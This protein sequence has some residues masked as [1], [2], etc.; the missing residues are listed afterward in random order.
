MA[1]CV[2]QYQCSQF[3]CLATSKLWI[4]ALV[5]DEIMLLWGSQCQSYAMLWFNGWK[6]VGIVTFTV[7]RSRRRDFCGLPLPKYCCLLL[8]NFKACNCR[9]KRSRTGLVGSIKVENV[10]L[11][12]RSYDFGG[13]S[14]SKLWLLGLASVDV[15][16]L[17][18]GQCRSSNIRCQSMSKLWQFG[19]VDVE[20][21]KCWIN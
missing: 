8:F 10:A 6:K 3:C 2:I 4:L 18:A 17:W 20:G 11:E 13:Q 1:S 7:S 16:T 9:V 15:M 12:C 5:S 14:V 21:F 19:F